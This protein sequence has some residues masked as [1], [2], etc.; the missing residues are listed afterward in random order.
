M[1]DAVIVGARCAGSATALHLAKRGLKVLLVDRAGFPS[2]TLST[3]FLWSRGASYLNRM[4][5]YDRVLKQTPSGTAIRFMRDGISFL[6]R[7]P[8]EEVRKR[9][10]HVHGAG[11]G[12]VDSYVSVRRTVLD[13]LLIEAACEAGVEFRSGP[14]VEELTRE[15]DRVTGV[16]GVDVRGRHTAFHERAR[17][18]IGADGRTSKIAQLAGAAITAEN[19]EGTFAYYTYFSGLAL[20]HA[21]MEKRG[22]LALV[23]V[24]TNH[25]QFMTLVF[26]PKAWWKDFL[27]DLEGNFW[28]AME[29]VD[30]PLAAQVRAAKREEAFHGLGDQ[31]AFKRTCAGPGWLLVGDAACI[32]DQCT[33]IGMTHAFRDAELATDAV[34]RTLAGTPET[35]ALSRYA[36]ARD[37]DLAGYYEF[38]QRMA[39]MALATPDDLRFMRVL[40]REPA[41]AD[42]FAAMYG[43]SMRV[44]DFTA[45]VRPRVLARASAA[46]DEP[47]ADGRAV[48]AGPAT[49]RRAS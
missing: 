36:S 43:D 38:V 12:A 16:R 33:A 2:D 17:F 8:V 13:Q 19:E 9:L 31:R 5:V 25:G 4:G 3:H 14:N 1:W 49:S 34:T 10:E 39:G 37:A 24:P 22:R 47:A 6:A 18:V 28:R 42:L 35:D 20:D 23:I 40:E 7:T 45:E 29:W 32:K 27:A 26:G 30:A 11:D 48:L 21:V 46:A 15:G 44:D 41:E